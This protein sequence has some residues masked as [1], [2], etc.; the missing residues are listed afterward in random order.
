MA[1][2][3]DAARFGKVERTPQGFARVPA[4][5]TR[6]GVFE[7]LRADGSVR[8][9]LR[10]REE[11]FAPASLATL[12]AAPVTDMHPAVGLVTP[13]NVK[14]LRVGGVLE[15]K[16]DGLWVSAVLQIEDAD[17]IDAVLAKKRTENSCGY[18]CRTEETPGRY[19]AATGAFG[20]DVTGGVPYDAIQRNIEYNHNALLPTG[21]ARA[22]SEAC[23]KLDSSDSDSGDVARHFDDTD[24]TWSTCG[25]SP[26]AAD[27]G[28]KTMDFILDGITLKL[29]AKDVE[30]IKAALA[31]RD[32]KIGELEA[33]AVTATASVAAL[34]TKLDAATSPEAVASAVAARV[35]LETS[36]RKVLG[37]EEKFDGKS[38]AEIRAA[39]LA[40][41]APETKLDGKS[42]EFV[43]A[44][45]EGIVSAVKPAPA[46][47]ESK[48]VPTTPRSVRKDG[49]PT[50][51]K[52]S[53]RDAMIARR[54]AMS[55]K[56]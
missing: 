24:D 34:Q 42:A 39:V 8:R 55:I 6:V 37:A 21:A 22:G 31:K 45:Y 29:D 40:K 2:R 23:I 28:A 3:S 52:L 53:P 10:P 54:N 5:L 32:A 7:Y 46:K 56:K 48:P 38:D 17:T 44:F 35:S 20:P 18:R 14:A 47:T 4:R 36:A 30:V 11:V 50:E 26:A 1:F 49:D 43:A 15:H 16:E 33:G 25:E 27:I 12:R 51:E 13:R 9:E 19:D 41:A